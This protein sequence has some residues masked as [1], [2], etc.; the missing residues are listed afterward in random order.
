VIKHPSGSLALFVSA[1]LAT[2][3]LA[4][5]GGSPNPSTVA[6]APAD[7]AAGQV[8]AAQADT[9]KAEAARLEAER[10][11]ELGAKEKELA[12][13]EAA[14]KQKELEQELAKRDA[15]LAA[16][17]T[18]QAGA[19]APKKTAAPAKTA[20]AP[21]PAPAKAAPPAPIVVPAGTPLAITLA[22]NV[23]TKK[24]VVGDP[25]QGHLSS[26]V[27]VNGKRAVAA[28]AT[29]NGSVT[30]VVS[31]SNKIGGT[32]TLGLAFSQIVLANGK[33]IPI[34]GSFVQQGESETGK[35]TAKIVGGAAAGAIIGHQV[36]SKNGA[37]VGG[38]LGGAAGTAAAQKTGGEVK[39]TAGSVIT[40]TT[41]AAFQV[42]G[43]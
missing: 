22:A 23:N 4:G 37:I 18:A 36:S 29:V 28:G 42:D 38:V 17:R 14:V 11:V 40:V 26:D 32:P 12:D 8:E 10:A 35:D 6:P 20:A 21:A 25:V 15:E 5:C 31:G 1:A 30:Q 13:R 39:L 24:A 34:T 9:A 3:A 7:T 16:A 2:F 27:V 19:A 41:G 33:S 43:G